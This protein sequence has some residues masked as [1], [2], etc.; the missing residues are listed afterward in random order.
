MAKSAPHVTTPARLTALRPHAAVPAEKL[1]ALL[2]HADT[3][4]MVVDRQLAVTWFTTGAQ[5]LWTMDADDVGRSLPEL[6]REWGEDELAPE[7]R[8]ALEHG[9]EREH[10][11]HDAQERLHV[12]RIRPVTTNG[13]PAEGAV[14][15]FSPFVDE[16]AN[17]DDPASSLHQRLRQAQREAHEAQGTKDQFLASVSH[18]LRTPLSAIVLWARLLAGTGS[19]DEQQLGEGITAIQRSAEELRV[20]IEALVD[21]SRLARGKLQLEFGSVELDAVARTVLENTQPAANEKEIALTL[22]VDPA[23]GIVRADETRLTQALQ[24]L[25]GNAIKF[26]PSGGRVTIRA[27]RMADQVEIRVADNGAGITPADLPYIFNIGHGG[28][29]G[30]LGL[31][32]SVARQ[33]VELH[34]GTLTADSDGLGHGALFTVRLPLPAIGP[35]R[36]SNPVAPAQ[37]GRPLA[38]MRLLLVE[39]SAE[40]RRALVL[41]LSAA[42]AEVT[43]V[44]SSSKALAIFRKERPDLIVSDLG[45]PKMDGYD[46]LQQFRRWEHEDDLAPVPALALTAFAGERIRRRALEAGFQRCL[47]KPVQTEDLVAELVALRQGHPQPV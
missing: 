36:S 11:V 33:L 40:T 13:G 9:S 30:G 23:V 4:L 31:G 17:G 28:H 26:T 37:P 19:D 29:N 6:A 39:D 25:V 15:T 47:I 34:G 46:L 14:V 12:C 43:A 41:A 44:D 8:L 16:L 42:G 2:G 21:A 5:Q 27:L 35:A 24:Q 32:L 22:E 3:A 10:L 20:M 18:E 7:V 38:G 45:L 1:L